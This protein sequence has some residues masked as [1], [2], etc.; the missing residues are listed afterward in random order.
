MGLPLVIM[1]VIQC[2]YY[3]VVKKSHVIALKFHV[4]FHNFDRFGFFVSQIS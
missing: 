3:T 1:S 4:W 2:S